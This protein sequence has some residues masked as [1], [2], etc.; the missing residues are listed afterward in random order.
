MGEV[1]RPARRELGL[2]FE[3]L[4]E[5]LLVYDSERSRAHSLNS[6]AARV[7]RA[8]DA[9]RDVQALAGE[10]GLDVETVLVALERLRS[11][12]LLEP[13]AGSPEPEGATRRAM[14]RKSVV[15]GAGVGLAIPVIRSITAPSL[16]MAA[17]TKRP[18]NGAPCTSSKSCSTGSGCSYQAGVGHC[19]RLTGRSCFY[20]PGSGGSKC[21]EIITGG[22]PVPC[23]PS[24]KCP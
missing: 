10:C 22:P 23:P 24:G 7:W 8:C 15:A 16:A 19:V 5:E 18:S 9:Q 2:L 12:D 1:Y 11:V 14:L 21:Q 17:S 6:T 13:P 3:P 4:G 20:S